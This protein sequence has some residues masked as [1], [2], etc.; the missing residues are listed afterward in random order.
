[1]QR[2]VF[3]FH[4]TWAATKTSAVCVALSNTRVAA[5]KQALC[6]LFQQHTGCIDLVGHTMSQVTNLGHLLC[7]LLRPQHTGFMGVPIGKCVM[8]MDRCT[9]MHALISSRGPSSVQTCNAKCRGC[10]GVFKG[11]A[12]LSG[13]YR[14]NTGCR[15]KSKEQLH[16]AEYATTNQANGGDEYDASSAAP[17]HQTDPPSLQ[18]R[19]MQ[20]LLTVSN[21]GPM[22]QEPSASYKEASSS[23]Q[24]TASEIMRTDSL[25][26]L[27]MQKNPKMATSASYRRYEKYMHATCV[28]SF[29]E[30]GGTHRDLAWDLQREFVRVGYYKHALDSQEGGNEGQDEVITMSKGSDLYTPDQASTCT[31]PPAMFEGSNCQV[32]EQGA[33]AV[34]GPMLPMEAVSAHACG[35]SQGG[36]DKPSQDDGPILDEDNALHD[37]ASLEEEDEEE[38]EE[39]VHTSGANHDVADAHGDSGEAFLS[40]PH[41]ALSQGK[42]TPPSITSGDK[43]ALAT[44]QSQFMKWRLLRGRNNNNRGVQRH[45]VDR[46]WSTVESAVLAAIG[47]HVVGAH[48][49]VKVELAMCANVHVTTAMVAYTT[50]KKKKEKKG[51]TAHEGD[52]L[53]MGASGVTDLVRL[54]W[55]FVMAQEE[56]NA[57]TAPMLL[58]E[59]AIADFK[60]KA[61]G[62]K[63]ARKRALCYGA[64]LDQGSALPLSEVEMA[65]QCHNDSARSD[66]QPMLHKSLSVAKQMLHHLQNTFKTWEAEGHLLSFRKDIT[67]I[68][69]MAFVLHTIGIPSQRTGVCVGLKFGVPPHDPLQTQDQT[70][71]YFMF[72][73]H[74]SNMWTVAQERTKNGKVHLLQVAHEVGGT[75]SQYV[76]Y[77]KVAVME[78]MRLSNPLWCK[79]EP[80][81]ADKVHMF[82]SANGPLAHIC[83]ETITNNAVRNYQLPQAPLGQ[84]RHQWSG[85]NNGRDDMDA[86]HL[87]LWARSH[88]T[89][90]KYYS[91]V[92]TYNTAAADSQVVLSPAI[93]DQR[94]ICFRGHVGKQY[95]IPHSVVWSEGSAGEEEA[96]AYIKCKVAM[97]IWVVG[98]GANARALMAYLMPQAATPGASHQ[99]LQFV[100]PPRNAHHGAFISLPGSVAF[101]DELIVGSMRHWVYNTTSNSTG[102]FGAY[103]MGTIAVCGT[104]GHATAALKKIALEH[105][106]AEETRSLSGSEDSIIDGSFTSKK[107]RRGTTPSIKH[108]IVP[109][110]EH[111]RPK[112]ASA[113]R[114]PA[115]TDAAKCTMTDIYIFMDVYLQRAHRHGS[116]S[117]N[118]KLQP[119]QI[120]LV[121]ATGSMAQVTSPWSRASLNACATKE[122]PIWVMPMEPVKGGGAIGVPYSWRAPHPHTTPQRMQP[123]A[124]CWPVDYSVDNHG[125]T[126]TLRRAS[127]TLGTAQE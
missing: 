1:M 30:L 2:C 43:T 121:R 18:Q 56:G 88:A 39:G 6:V 67:I 87:D 9:N 83:P 100:L 49:K 45:T 71:P 109:N 15:H 97:V 80:D 119:G 37:A 61:K 5:K 50:K 122:S 89:S 27:F 116:A 73:D 52:G 94:Q 54:K 64:T 10:G 102:G 31:S 96:V 93:N 55:L 58:L 53:K 120:V 70:K 65:K 110:C 20:S 63:A 74:R 124:L 36:Q 107:Q 105:E 26:L 90:T 86:T 17:I 75:L 112:R 111:T 28:Q 40:P 4:N 126:F 118:G 69:E 32:P 59:E 25:P 103:S 104:S 117:V 123:T 13:H 44:L 81:A 19:L 24:W 16:D 66:A 60:L 91:D 42:A 48:S 7:V 95:L 72:T 68:A 29:K 76:T 85:Y 47:D 113:T 77:W 101:A 127:F 114:Q 125:A 84:L 46:D 12:A 57:V 98:S 8:H 3:C 51:T 106:A 38:E 62:D 108:P 33:G 79:D 34:H 115:A 92:G 78:F 41:D 14:W 22:S 35:N 23:G 99:E 11:L 21:E 82:P